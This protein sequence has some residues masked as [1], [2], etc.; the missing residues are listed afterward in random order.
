MKPSPL[1]LT[2]LKPKEAQFELS[3]MKDTKLT[4]CAFS[5]RVR[6]H[7]MN[8]GGLEQF[9]TLLKASNVPKICEVV[10]FM[11]KEKDIF[12]NFDDFLQHI[13][14]PLDELAVVKAL[15][16]SMGVSEPKLEEI[17]EEQKRP[18]A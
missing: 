11:L 12:E 13:L 14:T 8:S 17:I 7:I 9:Y 1:D 3:S 18:K 10:F 4:V 2:D 6:I 15:T 5:L 16:Y